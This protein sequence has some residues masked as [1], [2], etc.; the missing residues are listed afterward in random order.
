MTPLFCFPNSTVPICKG[1]RILSGSR[2]ILFFSTEQEKVCLLPL[3]ALTPSKF[4][5]INRRIEYNVFNSS[6]CRYFCISSDCHPPSS[7]LTMVTDRIPFV[8][9]S[10]FVG[11]QPKYGGMEPVSTRRRTTPHYHSPLINTMAM[12]HPLPLPSA[13]SLL[14]LLIVLLILAMPTQG[15]AM[16]RKKLALI[17]G[18]KIAPIITN[19]HH[20]LVHILLVCN[21]YHSSN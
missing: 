11:R 14:L 8:C 19:H 21:I 7:A 17:T 12:G 1:I 13:R 10:L 3:V 6:V 9:P 16:P 20:P 2:R 18:M 15:L 4:N 5:M